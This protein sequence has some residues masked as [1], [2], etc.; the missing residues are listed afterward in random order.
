MPRVARGVG[1]LLAG[2][3]QVVA[4]RHAR[5]DEARLAVDPEEL[6]EQQTS[7]AIGAVG[8]EAG[9]RGIE[10][11]ASQARARA[12]R[13]VGIATSPRRARMNTTAYRE[14][15]ARHGVASTLF[16]AA[17]RAAGG[18]R[19]AGALG[20]AR[21]DPQS[22]RR[23]NLREAE[24]AD[25]RMLQASDLRSHARDPE[26]GLSQAFLNR[27][28]PDRCVAF[29]EGDTL[30]SYGWYAERPTPI[31]EVDGSLVLHFDPAYVYMYN[32]FTRPAYRGRRLHAVGMAAALVRYTREG[33]RGIVSYVDSSNYA[34]LRSCMRM[35]YERFGRVLFVKL[36]G[37]Y[38]TYASR[39]AKDRFPRRGRRSGE[40]GAGAGRGSPDRTPPGSMVSGQCQSCIERNGGFVQA[41]M[42]GNRLPETTGK[43]IATSFEHD[44]ARPVNGYAAPQL[45]THVVFFNLTETKTGEARALQPHELYRSQQYAT[46]IYR[47]EL[48]LRLKDGDTRSK[49]GRAASRKLLDIHASIWMLP[50]R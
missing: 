42:G 40:P 33:K 11:A 6:V 46:A 12:P 27:A 1:P 7:G 18:R 15:L 9:S 20:R 28:G 44:S 21:A 48:A 30:T 4:G 14:M 45:H 43:W 34:S 49:G 22:P 39:G 35:G 16:H 23:G 26:S 31:T 38:L 24:H 8:D 2:Q 3:R 32:G 13:G 25:G 50:V 10:G 47:S 41:R 37:R 19:P 29:F 36:G 5:R 17:Y